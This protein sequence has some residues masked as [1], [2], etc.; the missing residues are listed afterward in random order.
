MN[1]TF[2]IL[3]FIPTSIVNHIRYM[4]LSDY[5]QKTITP[6][7]FSLMTIGV[8]VN[9]GMGQ[10]VALLKIPL[11]LDS[12]GTVIVAALCGILPAMIT[13]AIANLLA[14]AVFSPAMMFF[15]PTVIV[16]AILAGLFTKRGFLTSWW[17]AVIAGIVVGICAAIV[18]APISA[19]L[20]GGITLGGTD[21]L[22][23]YFR[24][25][26]QELLRAV[27]YQGLASDPVDKGITFLLAYVILSKMPVNLLM[28]FP[29]FR[30]L[31]K[32]Q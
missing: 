22:V 23:L 3:Q 26:G 31:L 9:L 24:A 18:S 32:K 6:P 15:I 10:L 14:S 5:L 17:K 11:Y 12:L 25:T 16:I 8:A 28:R 27:L 21:F 20:F 30:F 19:Y 7:V 13:G 2:C 29:G 1:A 4:R